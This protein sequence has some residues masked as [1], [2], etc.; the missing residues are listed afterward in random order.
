MKQNIPQL[1]F[2]LCALLALSA[3]ENGDFGMASGTFEST[4]AIVSAEASGRILEFNVEEGMAIK[5]GQPVGK[6]DSV[7]LKEQRAEIAAQIAA[8]RAKVP[9][10]AVQLA[11][12]KEELAK[13]EFEKARAEKLIAAKSANQKLLDDIVSQIR[14]IEKKM[15]ASNSTLEKSVKEAEE[16]SK[17]LEARRAQIDDAISKALIINPV[18][19]TVLVKYAELG[20]TASFGKPLYKIAPLESL[21][22][23]AYF[24]AADLTQIKLGQTLKIRT[25]FG[26]DSSR[27]YDGV[28]TWIS[29]KSEF[30]PKGIRTRDERADLVYAVKILVKND[31]Y[32][33]IGQYAEVEALPKENGKNRN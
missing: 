20:E 13:Q 8:V 26:K 6:I 14:V 25:D 33:K 23:R 30:T 29:D 5:A 21:F 17:A 31:G 22:L 32:L 12:L 28:V 24:S 11:S 2:P 3:C 18:D 4:E 1:I 16:T 9:D 7:Q 19:G 10:V 27:H 15:E